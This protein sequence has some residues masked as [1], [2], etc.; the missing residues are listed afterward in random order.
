MQLADLANFNLSALA[1][2]SINLCNVK[3]VSVGAWIG[4]VMK[5]MERRL[6]EL[7]NQGAPTNHRQ[8]F[9]TFYSTQALS[10]IIA[11]KLYHYSAKEIK[12]P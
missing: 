3:T 6:M 8:V 7:P 4:L 9:G 12:E 11:F 5:F 10:Q 1:M 2:D